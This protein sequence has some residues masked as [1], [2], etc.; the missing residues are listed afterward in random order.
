MNVIAKL[1]RRRWIREQ[2]LLSQLL[3]GVRDGGVIARRKAIQYLT[4]RVLEMA[5]RESLVEMLR[6][7]MDRV[8][9][10]LNGTP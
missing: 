10:H 7:E 6:T 3:A 5:D 2:I 1:E 4:Q 8:E 9:A